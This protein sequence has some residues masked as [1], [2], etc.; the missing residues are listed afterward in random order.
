[1]PPV[2]SR[3]TSSTC[4]STW[5]EQVLPRRGGDSESNCCMVLTSLRE[6]K[7]RASLAASGWPKPQ[8]SQ[9]LEN[10][11]TDFTIP[12]D[13]TIVKY[14]F[15]PAMGTETGFRETG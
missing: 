4:V 1:M 10:L 8:F 14:F 12:T 5:E 15:L 9:F 13:L 6:T 3:M 7:N 11:R 2:R